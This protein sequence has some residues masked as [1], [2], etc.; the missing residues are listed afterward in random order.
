MP[1]LERVDLLAPT[2]IKRAGQ[3]FNIDAVPV[4]VATMGE[5]AFTAWGD[6]C[7]R[8]FSPGA[9]PE[10][11]PVHKGAVLSM[12]TEASGMILTGGGDGRFCR[13]TP[14]GVTEIAAFPRKWVD[15][16]AAGAGGIHACSVGR[17][18]HLWDGPRHEVLAAPSIVGGL[19]LDRKGGRLAVAH[20]GGV[21]VWSREKRGWKPARLTW[22][23]NLTAVSFSPDD[24]FVMTRMQENALHGCRLR[25][26]FDLRMS[27]QPT[28]VKGWAWT[29]KLSCPATTGA[30][31]AILWPFDGAQG[32]MGRGPMQLC[33]GA[34]GF[35]TAICTLPG[36]EA[37]LAGYSSG[38]V[39]FSEIDAA[40][41]P[42]AIKRPTGAA[43]TL[44]AVTPQTGWLLAADDRGGVL[45]A[46][47]MQDRVIP[48]S[49]N[50]QDHP[51]RASR[52][53]TG[54]VALL[55]PALSS[56]S[57][58]A[59]MRPLQDHLAPHFDTVAIDLPGFGTAAKPRADWT[60]TAMADAL[61]TVIA[62]LRPAL[63]V[64]AGHAAGVALCHAAAEPGTAPSLILIAPTWRGPLPIMMG[65]R[66]PWLGRVVR[67]F[68]MP[69]LGPALYRLNLS[70]PVI[71][72]MARGHVYSARA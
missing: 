34:R 56:I 58:R 69:L 36:H 61:S 44:L 60:P 63:I 13:I 23:G 33:W 30:D 46:G 15:H 67:V 51:I 25:D 21:T 1:V 7:L 17:E 14:E 26:K 48:W 19:A 20:Y 2:A 39:I 5:T 43:I 6:E 35:V 4:A 42:H 55:L 18:V 29:G 50:G 54:P 62:S 3:R 32:P 41:E 37:V 64:A 57:T 70:H 9:E 31:E 10:A 53:G 45:W 52:T 11:L 49:L 8:A 65:R 47:V 66:A 59:E 28:K 72:M 40:A 12:V 38:A 24:R 22:A 71:R 68:D 27:G 16:V